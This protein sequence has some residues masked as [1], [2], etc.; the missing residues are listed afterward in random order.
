VVLFGKSGY[1]KSSLFNAGIYPKLEES[2]DFNL[3][4]LR[5]NYFSAKNAN[6]AISPVSTVNSNLSHYLAEQNTSPLDIL[7][8]NENSFWYWIKTIQWFQKKDK[9]ILFFDQFEELFTYPAGQV[10]AFSEQLAQLLYNKVP[11]Q[12]LKRMMELDEADTLTEE[13]HEFLYKVPEIK[14]VFAI[15]SDRLSQVNALTKHHPGILQDCYELSALSAEQ[16][17]QAI[18]QPASLPQNEVFSCPAFTYSEDAL[19]KILKNVANASDGKTETSTLQIVCRYIEEDLVFHQ[20]KLQITSE[21][22]GDVTDIFKEYY[23]GI[24]N[25]LT[26]EERNKI[27]ELIEDE[28]IDHGRRNPLSVGYIQSKFGIDEELLLRLEQTSLLR[29][30]RDASGRLLYEVSHDSLVDAIE[31]VATLRR[32]AAEEL[33]KKELEAKVEAEKARVNELRSKNITIKRRSLISFF[34]AVIS[35]IAVGFAYNKYDEA[36]KATQKA[37]AAADTA[38]RQKE[39]AINSLCANDLTKIQGL[40]LQAKQLIGLEQYEIAAYYLQ[41]ADS[42]YNLKLKR[43]IENKNNLYRDTSIFVDALPTDSAINATKNSID[44]DILKYKNKK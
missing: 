24:L 19:Q 8:P 36:N 27:Q 26:P 37:K 3:F 4:S 2:G 10:D 20:Q 42:I 30:E 38:K 9:F 16:T 23:E 33:Q 18:T 40:T 28:L 15:R 34:F 44:A 32:A 13:L 35:L 7:I 11:A 39:I 6:E 21:L 5:F 12:F 1:G 29:K 22:L 17:I 43:Y 14:V 31:R 25:K 41:A